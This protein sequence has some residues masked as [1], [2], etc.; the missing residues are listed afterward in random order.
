MRSSLKRSFLSRSWITASLVPWMSESEAARGALV[1][2]VFLGN[3]LLRDGD[4]Q[5]P[6]GRGGAR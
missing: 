4:T 2:E 5:R 6:L 1:T 3:A